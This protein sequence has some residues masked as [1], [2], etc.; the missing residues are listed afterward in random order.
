MLYTGSNSFLGHNLVWKTWA[1]LKI[2]IFLWL[3]LRR[4]HWIGDRR[5]RHGLDAREQCHLCDQEIET[6]DHLVANCSYTREVWFFVLQALGI[7]LPQAAPTTLTWWRRL[8]SSSTPERR[9]GLDS[10]FT[11]ISWQVWKERNARCFRGSS[12]AI[13]EILPT[14]KAEAERWMDTGAQGLQVLCATI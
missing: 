5:R 7:Q 6:I 10:L 13:R 1:P 11:L 2:K 3:A 14:I 12:A 9:P 4:R 8:R